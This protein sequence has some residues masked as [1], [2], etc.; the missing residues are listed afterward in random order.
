MKKINRNF[1]RFLLRIKIKRILIGLLIG[2]YL[3][4]FAVMMWGAVYYGF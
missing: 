1:Y 4:M 3:V 2:L